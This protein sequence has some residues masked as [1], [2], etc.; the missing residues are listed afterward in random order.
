MLEAKDNKQRIDDRARVVDFMYYI[1]AADNLRKPSR[2][3][4]PVMLARK[5]TIPHL[6]IQDTMGYFMGGQRT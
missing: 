4:N 1:K 5:D 2:I 6:G 3:L